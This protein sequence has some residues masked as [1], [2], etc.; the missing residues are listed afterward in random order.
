M[1]R[2]SGARRGGELQ[3]TVAS[4]VDH[5]PKAGG[6]TPAR[7]VPPEVPDRTAQDARKKRRLDRGAKSEQQR[8]RLGGGT[9]DRR[10]RL[11]ERGRGK[12]SRRRVGRHIEDLVDRHAFRHQASD[13]VVI[14]ESSRYV[15][16]GLPGLRERMVRV[17]GPAVGRGLAHRHI[18]A[19]ALVIDRQPFRRA[20]GGTTGAPAA[21][22]VASPRRRIPLP[23]DEALAARIRDRLASQADVTERKMFGG[24]AFLVCGHMAVAASG[25]GGLMVRV[26]PA[27]SEHLVDTTPAELVVMR[28]RPMQGWLHLD[29]ADVRNGKALDAWVGRAL[30]FTATLPAKG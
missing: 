19:S 11:H 21:I 12:P 27:T 1:R 29:A 2:A 17:L 22:V 10:N 16:R 13:R 15:Q 7:V 5:D 30:R 18:V 23:F 3:P 4:C 25:Q 24:L 14:A 28:G 20:G 26:D 9:V 8:H 6:V